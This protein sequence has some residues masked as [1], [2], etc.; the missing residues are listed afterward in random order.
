[1]KVFLCYRRRK[2]KSKSNCDQYP[3]L[4]PQAMT[5]APRNPM[6]NLNQLYLQQFKADGKLFSPDNQ[7]SLSTAA[8]LPLDYSIK[9]EKNDQSSIFDY[10]N[11][12]GSSNANPDH[13]KS[14]VKSFEVVAKAKEVELSRN[15]FGIERLMDTK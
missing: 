9:V 5:S 3:Q 11:K 14:L 2:R 8:L 15:P 7:P 13:L 10:Q 1:M 12:M 4:P 6:E